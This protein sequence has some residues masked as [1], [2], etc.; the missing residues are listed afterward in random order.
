MTTAY[1][2]WADTYELFEGTMS[3]DTWRQG[4]GA[5]LIKLAHGPVRILD[6]GAGT[7]MGTRVLA[8]LVPRGEVVSLDRSAAMLEHGGIPPER[9]I[10]GDM[11]DFTTDPDSFDFVVSGFDALNYLPLADLA[12]CLAGAAAALRQGGHLVFDYSSRK[13]LQEDWRDLEHEE[14]RN[15]VRLHRRHRW[16][17]ALRRSRS[18][19]TLF[20]AERMLWRETHL[21]Y[22]VDPFTM[23]EI[24]RAAGLSTV[25][26]RDI[27]GE[28]FTPGHTTH[29][30]VLRKEGPHSRPNAGGRA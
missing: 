5:E 12:G 14:S 2:N 4:I 28:G 18:V 27:D 1:E 29:V 21:Q 3:E 30:Y 15:G 11:A 8:E 20:D 17:P 22:V 16:D 9:R 19:L 26:V 13:V 25:R 10:V 7:G 23:E 6:L 24:G